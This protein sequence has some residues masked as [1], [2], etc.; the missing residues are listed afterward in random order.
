[1]EVKDKIILAVIVVV[2]FC[3]LYTYF[4]ETGR[5]SSI[6]IYV[7]FLPLL[8]LILYLMFKAIQ[9]NALLNTGGTINVFNYGC[10]NPVYLQIFDNGKHVWDDYVDLSSVTEYE[11]LG[12]RQIR[13]VASDNPNLVN[14]STVIYF[15]LTYTVDSGNNILIILNPD[16]SYFEQLSA[17]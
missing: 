9:N 11:W 3:A 13:A 12:N 2:G 4:M 6:V 8:A 7:I 5:S 1:M 17:L 14:P 10:L 15:D 16:F